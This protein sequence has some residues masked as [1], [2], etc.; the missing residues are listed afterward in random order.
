MKIAILLLILFVNISFI[1][2]QNVSE[3]NEK[4]DASI[5]FYRKKQFAGSGN[6]IKI[7]I[8]SNSIGRLKVGHR[9]IVK[10]RPEDTV[11]ITAHNLL[12]GKI[13][14][15]ERNIIPEAGEKYYVE[16]NWDKIYDKERPPKL[17][18]YGLGIFLILRNK[19]QGMKDF[20]DD[21]YFNDHLNNIKVILT[22]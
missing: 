12:L 11:V 21:K 13:N 20:N 6:R 1:V 17:Q 9:L 10:V 8:N 15:N 14:L 2:G 4:E 18:I 7:L 3:R 22:H 19:E 16:T 5:Y